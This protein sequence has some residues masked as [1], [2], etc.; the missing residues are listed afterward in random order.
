MRLRRSWVAACVAG[1]LASHAA[2]ETPAG[3]Y[4]IDV[5][6]DAGL[7]FPFGVA[8]LCED[9]SGGEVCLSSDV[10]T[11]ASGVVTG[12]AIMTVEAAG[13]ELALT[14]DGQILGTTAKPKTVLDFTAEGTAYGYE[15]EAEGRMRCA[16]DA[17]MPDQQLC[18]GKA[19]VCGFVG[20]VRVGCKRLPFATI[21]QL[22]R[23]P[24]VV[25]LD[26]AT[27][28]NGAVSGDATVQVDVEG[29]PPIAYG[30][31]GKYKPSTDVSNLKLPS[32]DPA[33]KTSLA[34]QGLELAAGGAT[35]GSV[36]FKIAGQKGKATLPTSAEVS[37]FCSVRGSFCDV[38]L[39]TS[40]LSGLLGMGEVPTMP[41][42]NGFIFYFY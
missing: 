15:V 2:A 28:G 3:A 5:S 25:A 21:L 42:S 6:G 23:V 37:S 13:A 36:A 29:A 40:A 41:P 18:R 12:A 30:A 26:L 27:A 1:L 35:A 19:K 11:D 10:E 22:E 34:F 16:L 33:Q 20:G 8:E 32:A 9:T 7:A 14:L 17:T 39:D 38:N 4:A 24:F 31:K